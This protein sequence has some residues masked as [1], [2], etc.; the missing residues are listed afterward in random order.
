MANVMRP[1]SC[2]TNINAA[3]FSIINVTSVEFGGMT[4]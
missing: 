3:I 2:D 1:A 4:T